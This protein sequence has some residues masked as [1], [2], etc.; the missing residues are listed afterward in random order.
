VTTPATGSTPSTTTTTV[1]SL[2]TFGSS[3]D[4]SAAGGK[5][6]IIGAHIYLYGANTSGWGKPSVSLLKTTAT[7]V[8]T[9][10]DGAYVTSDSNGNFSF[11]NK[12][13]C[14]PGQQVY[15]FAKNG[16]PGHSNGTVNYV[17]G[18]MSIFGTCPE[19]GTFAGYIPYFNINE[20]TTVATAY[21][22]AGFMSDPTHVASGSSSN[23]LNGLGN[24]FAAYNNLVDLEDGTA[25]AYNDDENGFVPLTKINALA[26]LLVP[27]VNSIATST[28]CNTLFNATKDAGGSV[29]TNTAAAV[30]AMAHNPGRNVATLFGIASAN[31]P[32]QPTL[33]SA[34]S[35]WT[36]SI[37]FFAD[38][39]PG[40]YY[41][42]VD[43]KGYLW[44]PS[45]ANASVVRFNPLGG[46]VGQW[47]AG[48]TIKQPFSIAVD[49]SDNVYVVNFLPG[50][51]TISRMQ[52]SGA[53]IGGTIACGPYCFFPAFDTPGNLWV[54]G[55]DKTY[56]FD[57]GGN[58]KGS[59]ATDAYTSGVG[60]ATNGSAWTLGHAGGLYHFTL[61][62]SATRLTQ[63]LTATDG[64]DITPVALDASDNV[65]FLSGRNSTLGKTDPNGAMISPSI[66]YT[67]GG[68]S[69]PAG[70]AIDGAGRV[71]VANR[72]NSSISEF[73]TNGTA[74]SPATGF[75][76]DGYIAQGDVEVGIHGPRGI[77]VDNAGNVWVSNFTYNSVTELLGAATPVATPLSS[78]GHGRLP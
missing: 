9:D 2:A 26:N 45:Y 27:C 74:L 34:P 58:S 35:D 15:V 11:T 57:A 60:I 17:I 55:T 3:T 70:L 53:T 36:I 19:T 14:T 21:A 1:G 62:S 30:L 48:N 31:A 10:S 22:L 25:K 66:G 54:T 67:G 33:T 24:A 29:P 49:A 65:W 69:S 38:G 73:D 4:G 44:V 68:M 39:M 52:S 61:P 16:N 51:S 59:F 72:G 41:L 6:A 12:Y 37:T 28:A 56:V 40:P 5:Q 76:T 23:A 42:A 50:A 18:L 7:G 47:N 64:N 32:Y 43:S 63:Q 75:G 71:W 8:L 13:S 46:I 78:S 77:V 20:V